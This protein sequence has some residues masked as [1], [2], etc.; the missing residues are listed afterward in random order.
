ML[1]GGGG[2]SPITGPQKCGTH[3]GAYVSIFIVQKHE[4]QGGCL[5]P[6]GPGGSG[7]EMEGGQGF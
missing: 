3:S 6:W 1:G 2:C 7:K 4:L 5:S